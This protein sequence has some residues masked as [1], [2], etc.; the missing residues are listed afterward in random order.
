[1][2]L[3]I[4]QNPYTKKPQELWKIIERYDDP[5]K[6]EATG[7]IDTLKRLFSKNPKFII[8]GGGNK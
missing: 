7:G 6:E 2:Q 8:K 4:A 1:M 5:D 3:A